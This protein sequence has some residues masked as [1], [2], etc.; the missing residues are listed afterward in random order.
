MQETLVRRRTAS[1]YAWLVAV[2]A[3]FVVVQG[4]LFAA[5][6]SERDGAYI[7][8]HEV[9]GSLVGLILLVVLVP[10][11]FLAR[12]PGGPRIGWWTVLLTVLW[13]VQ[14]ILGYG[15]ADASWLEIVHIPLA[16]GIFGLAAYLAFRGFRALAGAS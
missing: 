14:V 2:I 13:N 11:G 12:F 3:S 9:V 15:I 1:V 7:D 6:Y 4:T 16:F 10:L 5:F 8:A